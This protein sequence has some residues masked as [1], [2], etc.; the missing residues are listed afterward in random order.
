MAAGMPLTDAE[1]EPWLDRLHDELVG[2]DRIVVT[3]SALRRPYRDRLR[4]PGGVRFVFLDVDADEATRR[5]AARTGHFMGAGMVASQFATL[6]R[7]AADEGDVI[8]VDALAD[9]P[10]SLEAIVTRLGPDHPATVE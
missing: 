6:E 3:C 7:P 4:E 8:A 5:V 1:R 2:H 9:V 10:S